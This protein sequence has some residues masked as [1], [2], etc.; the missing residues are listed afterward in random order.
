MPSGIPPSLHAFV[1]IENFFAFVPDV[2]FGVCVY[3]FIFLPL[4]LTTPQVKE[5]QCF[6]CRWTM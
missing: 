6:E 4:R 2:Y 5:K 1:F 3:L